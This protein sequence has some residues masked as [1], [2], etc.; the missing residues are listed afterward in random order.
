[1]ATDL[2]ENYLLDMIQHL[3]TR[4]GVVLYGALLNLRPGDLKAT[5]AFLEGEYARESLNFPHTVPPFDSGA[6]LWAAQTVYTGVQLLLARESMPGELQ[7]LLPDYTGT[8][9]PSAILSADLCLRFLP[10]VLTQLRA[11][12]EEDPLMPLLEKHLMRWHY[13]GV[14]YALDISALDFSGYTAGCVHALYSDR[15]IFHQHLALAMHPVFES[16]IRAAL[17][18]HGELLWKKFTDTIRA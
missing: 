14:N 5:G 8:Q 7:A 1:M 2:T 13:S 3:R 11:V 6:A 10:A 12:D 9:T 4:E 15:I 18:F 17:G 16:T